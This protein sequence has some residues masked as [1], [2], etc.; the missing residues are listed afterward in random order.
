MV[1]PV[2]ITPP[3]R[4]GGD[5][6]DDDSSSIGGASLLSVLSEDGEQR[7]PQFGFDDN[8]CDDEGDSCDDA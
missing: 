2:E 8:E 4:R 7:G 3:M 6:D 1:V 5:D